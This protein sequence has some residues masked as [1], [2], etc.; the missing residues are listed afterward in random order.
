VLHVL[1][2]EWSL[3]FKLIPCHL[4]HSSSHLLHIS[5][6]VDLV[7]VNHFEEVG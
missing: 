5:K 6:R 1:F 3:I 4:H 2:R 7:V